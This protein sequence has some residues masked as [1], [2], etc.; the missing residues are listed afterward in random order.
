MCSLGWCGRRLSASPLA[1]RAFWLAE[2]ICA[3]SRPGCFFPSPL[4]PPLGRGVAARKATRCVRSPR[5]GSRPAPLF[6]PLLPPLATLAAATLPT[7]V[8]ALRPAASA[9]KPAMPCTR[10]CSLGIFACL[11]YLRLSATYALRPLMGLGCLVPY[12]SVSRAAIS[13]PWGGRGV[14]GH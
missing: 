4:P 1:A 13:P 10:P 7:R 12:L 5:C 6:P 11:G 3:L 8:C 2:G 9:R 14:D